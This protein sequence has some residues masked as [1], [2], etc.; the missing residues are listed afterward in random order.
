MCEKLL[1]HSFRVFTNAGVD[2]GLVGCVMSLRIDSKEAEKEFNLMFPGSDDVIGG[3][4]IG[5]WCFYYDTNLHYRLSLIHSQ[6][7]YIP[8]L[9]LIDSNT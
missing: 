9:T 4:G 5:M 8:N 1:E 7:N 6:W 3:T 2:V